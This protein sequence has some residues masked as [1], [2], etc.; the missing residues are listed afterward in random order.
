MLWNFVEIAIFE[1]GSGE[2]LVCPSL[3]ILLLFCLLTQHSSYFQR[4]VFFIKL[5]KA[6]NKTHFPEET[7]TDWTGCYHTTLLIL[8]KNIKKCNNERSTLDKNGNICRD[9]CWI[10]KFP[11]SCCSS[12][13]HQKVNS[14]DPTRLFYNSDASQ[15][16]CG[17]D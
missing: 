1:L 8:L 15:M 16:Y 5:P 14:I 10:I 2:S 12:S 3:I 17:I 11:C 13:F 7:S 4:L 9:V 6:Q